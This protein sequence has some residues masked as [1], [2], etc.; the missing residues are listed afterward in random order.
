[1][2]EAGLIH[3]TGDAGSTVPS[4]DCV[5]PRELLGETSSTRTREGPASADPL[6]GVRLRS[7]IPKGRGKLNPSLVGV[8]A[9]LPLMVPANLN[10][11]PQPVLTASDY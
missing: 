3:R 4:R 5:R 10:A 9:L 1:M 2:S 6:V 11:V 7:L 8:P